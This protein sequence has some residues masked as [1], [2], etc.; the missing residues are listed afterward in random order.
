[1]TRPPDARG[2]YSFQVAS[3]VINDGMMLE[4]WDADEHVM[5]VFCATDGEMTVSLFRQSVPIGIVEQAIAE[6]KLRLTEAEHS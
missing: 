2:Q 4:V 3:D 1:M 6:A 5:E